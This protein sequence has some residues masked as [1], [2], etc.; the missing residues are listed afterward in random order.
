MEFNGK[1]ICP[2]CLE[3]GQKKGKLK[4]LQN[5]RICYDKLALVVAILPML[6]VWTSI[7]G[8]PIALYLSLRYR[9]EPCSIRGKSNLCFT[10]ATILAALQIIGWVI[11]LI[12]FNTK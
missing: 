10:L 5:S 9:K 8:A 1:H 2:T 12:Y 4:E 6:L 7:L 11:A 3:T